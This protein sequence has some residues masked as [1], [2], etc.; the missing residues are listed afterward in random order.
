MLSRLESICLASFLASPDYLQLQLQLDLALASS[1][2]PSPHEHQHQHPQQ[3]H[4]HNY[5]SQQRRHTAQ[6]QMQMQM[7]AQMQT[8]PQAQ[9]Q[10]QAQ[11]LSTAGV[12][13]LVAAG[14]R[15]ES[16]LTYRSDSR[17]TVYSHYSSRS[18]MGSTMGSRRRS[19]LP[20]TIAQSVVSSE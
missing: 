18:N 16:K 20:W 12:H 4:N 15:A 11:P 6:M 8:Q 13:L 3:T 5:T 10:A 9:A 19:D 14:D 17:S 2:P 1:M 7:Q